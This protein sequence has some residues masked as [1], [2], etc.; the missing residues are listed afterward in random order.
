APAI[1][2]SVAL[3][4][5]DLALDFNALDEAERQYESAAA[6][7]RDA[8]DTSGALRASQ[9]LAVLMVHRGQF[10]QA[11]RMLETVR[12]DYAARGSRRDAALTRLLSGWAETESGRTEAADRTLLQALT[13]LRAVGDPVSEAETCYALGELALR[14]GRPDVAD[15]TFRRGLARVG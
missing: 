14:R 6:R 3:A 8:K 5:A 4:R 13:E 7:Y 15:A 11:S 2:A 12:H 9:G 1:G 10:A